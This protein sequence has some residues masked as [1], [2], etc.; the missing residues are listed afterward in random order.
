MPGDSDD[1]FDER[2][3][4]AFSFLLTRGFRR[5]A[6]PAPR[7]R[8]VN[9][10]GVFV[11]VFHIPLERYT[12]FKVGLT[13]QPRDA[14][15]NEELRSVEKVQR[16]PSRLG[17]IESSEPLEALARLLEEHGERVLS[18]EQGVFEEARELRRRY[19]EQFTRRP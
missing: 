18:G 10:T 19:T 3:N 16:L 1:E 15:N 6:D 9:D 11:D 17:P 7:L 12:G 8:F 13:S 4:T 5:D 2:A 14:L